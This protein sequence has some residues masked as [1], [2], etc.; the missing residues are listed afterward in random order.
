LPSSNPID[1]HYPTGN[2]ALSSHGAL[3]AKGTGAKG[4]DQFAANQALGVKVS[5]D[6]DMEQYSTRV[7]SRVAKMRAGDAERIA[8]EIEKDTGGTLAQREDRNQLDAGSELDE[9]KLFGAV[10]RDDGGAGGARGGGGGGGGGGVGGKGLAAGVKPLAGGVSKPA[11]WAKPTAAQAA[12]TAAAAAAA[13]AAGPAKKDEKKGGDGDK[14]DA[15][16]AK[17]KS[18]LNPNAK[19]FQVSLTIPSSSL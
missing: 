9:E 11:P 8:Q 5:S 19:S 7:D 14:K 1:A 15:A 2:K 13:A 17:P 3:G 10:V 4:W 16:A 12:A 18:T 6:G